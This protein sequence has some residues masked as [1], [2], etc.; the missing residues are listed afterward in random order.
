MC[1]GFFEFDLVVMRYGMAGK[2]IPNFYNGWI[3]LTF[4]TT[5]KTLNACSAGPGSVTIHD[6]GSG[7]YQHDGH[8][9]G[10]LVIWKFLGI[11]DVPHQI[12]R[13]QGQ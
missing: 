2:D 7:S 12:F 8:L 13:L 4:S 1:K 6:P 3:Y 5:T 11:Y 9:N 10:S